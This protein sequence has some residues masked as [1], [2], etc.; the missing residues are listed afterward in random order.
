MPRPRPAAETA[1]AAPPPQTAPVADA[2]ASPPAEPTAPPTPETDAAD[3]P[4]MEAYRRRIEELREYG[5]E[6]EVEINPDSERDFLA[7]MPTLPGAQEAGV[8]LTY[9]GTLRASWCDDHDPETHLALEFLGDGQIGYVIFRIMPG[10][11]EIT[12]VCGIEAYDGIMQQIAHFQL[13]HL[14]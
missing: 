1:N 6:E 4:L 11:A 7:F 12:R 5:L 8:V 10:E 14:V 9:A 13:Q 2:Y 3:P